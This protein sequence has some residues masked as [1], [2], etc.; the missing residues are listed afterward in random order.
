MNFSI[1][2][3]ALVLLTSAIY[4][5]GNAQQTDDIYTQ[6][7]IYRNPT[8]VALNKF[9]LT[10]TTGYGNTN[11]QHDLEDVYF[12]Q[13]DGRQLI[14]GN[15]LE[16]LPVRFAGF[17]DWLNDPMASDTLLND[18]FFDVPYNYLPNPVFND[19][20]R[21][22]TFL[23]DTDTAAVNFQGIAHSIP[24]QFSAHYNYQ[25]FRFGFGFN[26]ERQ[27]LKQ[28]DPGTFESQIRPYQPNFK[29]TQFTRIF[30]MIGY[31]FY[32]YWDYA[33]VAELEVGRVT[34]GKQF[35]SELISRGIFTT[36]G[37]SIEQNWSEYFRIIIKPSYELKNY[38]VM[39]PDGSATINH[40]QNTFF[41]KFGISINIPEIPRSPMKSDHVQLKHV[42]T[43][44]ATGRLIEVRG[45]PIW[46]KQNPKVGENHRKLWRYKN[47]NK[48]K[49]NPY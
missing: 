24:I 6:Y 19:T 3:T 21:Q 1:R 10:F 14:L 36:I 41:L 17:S 44:P 38:N 48:R 40:K 15:G 2:N 12:Y 22:N 49:L 20:L 39:L 28:L 45:Q 46:K 4:L 43:D 18:N 8:R 29:S 27:T 32:E 33:F 30:G 9:A 31:K 13:D 16:A 7:N 5:T 11:Y 34:A 47:R 42:I 35:N 26:W 37:I 25:D 23:V